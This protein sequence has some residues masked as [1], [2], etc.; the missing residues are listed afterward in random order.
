MLF[1]P[2]IVSAALRASSLSPSGMFDL[3]TN[4]RGQRERERE[5]RERERRE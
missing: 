5:E 4:T 1:N 3:L 2:K